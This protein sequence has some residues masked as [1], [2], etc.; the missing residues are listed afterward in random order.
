MTCPQS[1]SN[2]TP[3][4]ALVTPWGIPSAGCPLTLW[5]TG[6]R[7]QPSCVLTPPNMQGPEGPSK[8]ATAL[9]W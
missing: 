2:W 3:V 8:L 1:P 7:C 9:E 5:D 4:P 6:Q